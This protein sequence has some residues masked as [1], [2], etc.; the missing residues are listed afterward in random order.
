MI[1]GINQDMVQKMKESK[2]CLKK[3]ISTYGIMG[4]TALGAGFGM[5]VPSVVNDVY[6][7]GV[8]AC[9]ISFIS[10]VPFFKIY[11]KREQLEDIETKIKSI[12]ESNERS[13]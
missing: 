3:Q 6:S 7:L 10:L 8:G 11:Q 4:A 1:K 9:F 13:L 2:K 12:E 5:M